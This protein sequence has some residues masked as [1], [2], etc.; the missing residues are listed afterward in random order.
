MTSALG[1]AT[2]N[3]AD[4]RWGLTGRARAIAAK[5]VDAYLWLGRPWLQ[6]QADPFDLPRALALARTSPF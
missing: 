6:N 1:Q 5:L 2:T 4:R 3:V